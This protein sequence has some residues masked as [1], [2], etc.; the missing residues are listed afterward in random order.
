MLTTVQI[1]IFSKRDRERQRETETDIETERKIGER[2]E[3]WREA[4]RKRAFRI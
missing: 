2:G 4:G 1:W 3:G